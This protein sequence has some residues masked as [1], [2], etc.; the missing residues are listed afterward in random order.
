MS[1]AHRI[2]VLTMF[3]LFCQESPAAGVSHGQTPQTMWMLNCQGCHRADGNGTGSAVPALSGVVSRFLSV[4]GGREY[5]VRVPG[6]AGSPLPDAQLTELVNWMFREFDPAN[7]P[8]DFAPYTE[9]EIAALRQMG[10][11]GKEAGEIRAA[12]LQSFVT[13]AATGR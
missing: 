4:P 6:V 7:I 11:Y 5:L 3:A 2:L 8:A 13:I 9:Q 1:S 10:A 12:L